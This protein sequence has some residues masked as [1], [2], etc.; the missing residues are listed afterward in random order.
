MSTYTDD[1]NEEFD[2]FEDTVGVH[3]LSLT[4]YVEWLEE[5]IS[6]ANMRLNAARADLEV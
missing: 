4:D 5:V 2:N 1:V 6:I 3:D